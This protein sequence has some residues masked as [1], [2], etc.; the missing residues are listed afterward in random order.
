M[1]IREIEI[2]SKCREFY[3]AMLE[4]GVFL[5]V[6]DKEGKIN[7]M[8]IGWGMI[9]VIW[10]EPVMTVLVRPLRHTYKLLKN[11]RYF[12]VSVP[13]GKLKEELSYCGSHS[14]EIE[15]KIEKSG[16][17]LA[18]GK[19][20][21]VKIVEGCD[22]YYECE[23]IHKNSLLKE[24]LEPGIIKKYYGDDSFHTLFY[25]KILKAYETI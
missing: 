7:V 13:G 25:G 5:C 1:G 18:N 24:T 3:E 17:K 22:L 6:E 19:I 20:Q 12:S 2:F 4:D 14:G 9:G 21:G 11:A 10:N 23:I 16:I 8:T 15:N